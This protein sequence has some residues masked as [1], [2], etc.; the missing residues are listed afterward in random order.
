[1]AVAVAVEL[2]HSHHNHTVLVVVQVV[3]AEQVLLA[4]VV[5]VLLEE[6]PTQAAP[7]IFKPL[8]RQAVLVILL[9]QAEA[10][11]VKDQ[12]SNGISIPTAHQVKMPDQMG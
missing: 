1:V 3:Q 7:M 8:A 6:T 2:N 4:T 5:L 9:V 12:L 10:V 11:V